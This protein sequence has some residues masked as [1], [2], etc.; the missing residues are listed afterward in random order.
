MQNIPDHAELK[1]RTISTIEKSLEYSLL[2]SYMV[3]ASRF[4]QFNNS[5]PLQK[6]QNLSQQ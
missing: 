2:A 1:S 4:Y 5:K 6:I 3:Q